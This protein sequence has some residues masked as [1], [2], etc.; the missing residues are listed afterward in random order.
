MGA[1]KSKGARMARMV[2]ELA[3]NPRG[4]LVDRLFDE[5]GIAERTRRQD[6]QELSNEL[7][8]LLNS[9]GL[10]LE[11]KKTSQGRRL[12]IVAQRE[13][14]AGEAHTDVASTVASF[15][16]MRNLFESLGLRDA[17]EFAQTEQESS[18]R[19]SD[20]FSFGS[21]DRKVLYVPQFRVLYDDQQKNIQ[22]VLRAIFL[23][24]LLRFNYQ[25]ARDERAR[26]RVI[27]PY[28]L[29]LWKG[30][31]YVYGARNGDSELRL[32]ALQRMT[33]PEVDLQ[34]EAFPYP[35]PHRYDPAAIFARRFGIYDE[36]DSSQQDIAIR[37]AANRWLHRYLRERNIHPSAKFR[38]LPNGELELTMRLGA[39][40]ECVAW[41]KSFGDDAWFVKPEELAAAAE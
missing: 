17:A 8:P 7:S 10:M 30:A 33:E 36:D 27:R 29:L 23:H 41:V 40:D 19:E 2:F 5:F 11:D 35:E 18:S 4:I 22:V 13:E 28:T 20:V 26:F 14:L 31:F 21:L 32:F 1:E 3:M 39:L 34:H 12:R 9:R 37:F 15:G 6:R 16:L 24:R 38:D 25:G